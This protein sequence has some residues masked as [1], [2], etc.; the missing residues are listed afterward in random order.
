MSCLCSCLWTSYSALEDLSSIFGP[1]CSAKL[2]ISL[3]RIFSTFSW[4]CNTL[5]FL[6]SQTMVIPSDIEGRAENH[7]DLIRD[8][9]PANETVSTRKGGFQKTSSVQ[10]KV[11]AFRTLLPFCGRPWVSHQNGHQIYKLTFYLP[12]IY[13]EQTLHILPTMSMTR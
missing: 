6:F 8:T 3:L 10:Q 13:C 7:P 4:H 5:F 11:C 2:L 12:C 1:P 9:S